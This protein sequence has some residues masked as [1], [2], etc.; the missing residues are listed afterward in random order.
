MGNRQVVSELEQR[1]IVF[2]TV[3][4]GCSM[5]QTLPTPGHSRFH[6]SIDSGGD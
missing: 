1:G 4:H 5:Q 3:I 6:D 2:L